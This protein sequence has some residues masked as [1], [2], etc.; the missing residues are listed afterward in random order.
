MFQQFLQHAHQHP[1]DWI[2]VGIGICLFLASVIICVAFWLDEKHRQEENEM[3]D[4]EFGPP[5][6]SARS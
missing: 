4:G 1:G 5:S 6:S 3:A 2:G